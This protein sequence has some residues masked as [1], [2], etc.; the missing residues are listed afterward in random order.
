MLIICSS[1]RIVYLSPFTSLT[2]VPN[3]AAGRPTLIRL[4]LRRG[5]HAA[6]SRAAGLTSYAEARV[7]ATLCELTALTVE[8]GLT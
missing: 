1:L 4:I 2:L 3:M 7:C 8:F 5:N 6:S